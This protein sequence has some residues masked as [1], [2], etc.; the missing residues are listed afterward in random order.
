VAGETEREDDERD[1][2]GD[3]GRDEAP[4]G[5]DAAQ[6]E[7][8]PDPNVPRNRAERRAMAKAARRGR[9][10]QLA[11]GSAVP[12]EG[13]EVSNDLLL[14][15]NTSI[16][17]DTP[18][19]DDAKRPKVPPRTISKGT[20]NAEGVPEWALHAGDWFTKNRSNAINVALALVL[21][22]GGVFG[23]RAYNGS[24][25][26]KATNA[27]AD[28]L[29]AA[30]AVVT[31][32][33]PAADDPRRDVLHYRTIED[34]SRAALER[35]RRAEQGNPSATVTPLVRLTEAGTLYQLGRYAEAKPLYLAALGGDLAGLEGRAIE[36]LAF[37]L[38]SLNDLDGAM[39]RYR[40][41][42]NVQDGVY[43]DQAQFYQAR[44]LV[45]RDDNAR[46]KD[47]LHSVIE[48]LGH[49]AASDP[50]AAF[51]SSLREQALGLL[52][53]IDPADPAVV[54]A[55]RQ[56]EAAGDG[57]EHGGRPGGDRDPLQGLPPELREQLQKAL[58]ERGG[59]GGGRP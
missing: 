16:G 18:R 44:V 33:E 45:R 42:Q 37:T 10:V 19:I 20:G 9:S 24:K 7:A 25:Q 56:R 52:R 55:D 1:E 11:D 49:P 54:A 40:E 5:D 50:T 36:G 53:D 38:E 46:A 22:F 30:F 17:G 13:D 32:E 4:E 3:E 43:R 6:A 2:N 28:A 23:W 21:A 31:P 34:R 14:G 51:Q 57:H 47:L 58:R 48:R 26:A 27:Y 15:L 12:A 41:L 29:Q 59:A 8:A 39:A 35:L